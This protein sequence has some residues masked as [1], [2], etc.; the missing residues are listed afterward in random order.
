[1][2]IDR[3]SQGRVDLLSNASA[4]GSWVLWPGGR[5]AVKMTGTWSSATAKLQYRRDKNDAAGVDV[6]ATNAALAANGMFG[7]ELPPGEIRIAIT[8]SPSAMY[9]TA[10]GTH[11]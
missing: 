5:G 6:D 1:M 8:G 4:T 10:E 3:R 9:A 7:F 2:T 11:I